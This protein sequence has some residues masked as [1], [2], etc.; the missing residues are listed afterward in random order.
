[1]ALI[2]CPECKSKISNQASTCPKCGCPMSEEVIDNSNNDKSRKPFK[3]VLIIAIVGVVIVALGIGIGIPNYKYHKAIQLLKNNQYVEANNILKELKIKKASKKARQIEHKV[4]QELVVKAQLGDI[5]KFGSYEQDDD[6]TNGA[7]SI[8]WIVIAKDDE[9]TLLLSKYGLDSHKYYEYLDIYDEV[10][11]EESAI[12]QW[13][14][15]SFSKEAFNED[16]R[17]IIVEG[18][19]VNE[20]NVEYGTNGGK[21]TL[22]QIFLLSTDEVKKYL[23]E[24]ALRMCLPSEYAFSSCEVSINGKNGNC[25]WWLRSPGKNPTTAMCIGAHGEFID[26]NSTANRHNAVRPAIWINH[27]Y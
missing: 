17:K 23:T 11:W 5:V 16:E 18:E 10:T 4:A 2:K 26:N 8:E 1:M 19:L 7:E 6:E 9:K 13:L 12:R 21:N 14:M 27:T 3:A 20:D 15:R 22:D 25:Y 24:E